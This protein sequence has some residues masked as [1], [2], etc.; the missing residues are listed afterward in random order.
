M[1][2]VNDFYSERMAEEE[3]EQFWRA[4]NRA[5]GRA[6]RL[7]LEI[8]AYEMAVEMYDRALSNYRG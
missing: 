6:E 1:I 2:K 8:K 7:D 3:R 4:L 5:K